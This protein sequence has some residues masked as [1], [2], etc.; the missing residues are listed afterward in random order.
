MYIWTEKAE[1]LG[2]EYGI[3]IKAGTKVLEIAEGQKATAWE[4]DGYIVEA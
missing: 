2:N 1:T 4:N 3:K